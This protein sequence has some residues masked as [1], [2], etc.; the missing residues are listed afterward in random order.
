MPSPPGYLRLFISDEALIPVAVAE[1]VEFKD[2]KIRE[3]AIET[4]RRLKRRA[5]RQPDPQCG[6]RAAVDQPGRILAALQEAEISRERMAEAITYL[7][8][9]ADAAGTNTT[10]AGCH[11][12]G[13]RRSRKH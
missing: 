10:I 2:K 13:T 1:P 12:R 4:A 11:K 3:T 5:Q 9:V 6:I 7:D 8:K